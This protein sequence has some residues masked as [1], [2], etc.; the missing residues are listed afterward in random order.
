MILVTYARA[1]GM[2]TVHINVRLV[3]LSLVQQLAK[4]STAQHASSCISTMPM[5]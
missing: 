2:T 4:F 1:I 3:P 5:E